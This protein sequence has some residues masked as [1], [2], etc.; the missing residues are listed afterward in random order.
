MA[1]DSYATSM[2]LTGHPGMA[3]DPYVTSMYPTMYPSFALD[4]L[5]GHPRVPLE[6]SMRFQYLPMPP[7]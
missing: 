4:P 3:L 1:L 6:S 5:S 2:N 7:F